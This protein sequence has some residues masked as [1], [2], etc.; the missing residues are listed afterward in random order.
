MG[1]SGGEACHNCRRLKA[2]LTLQFNI[3][4]T[5]KDKHIVFAPVR[6]PR[7][8]DA[9]QVVMCDWSWTVGGSWSTRKEDGVVLPHHR[10]GRGM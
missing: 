6:K 10:L 1:A 5:Q 3:G 4:A 7:P 8:V 9:S 2:G